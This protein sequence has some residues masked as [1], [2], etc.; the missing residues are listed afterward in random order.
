M[1]RHKISIL[2]LLLPLSAVQICFGEIKGDIGLLKMVADGYEAHLAK[3]KTWQ[4]QASIKS[5]VPR[6]TGGQEVI[7]QK[8]QY[9]ADFLIDRS[10]NTVRWRWFTIEKIGNK[11]GQE[12]K[13]VTR[14]LAGMSKGKCDYVLFYSGYG[15]RGE[16][17]SL[18]IY[19]RNRWPRHFEGIGFDPIH[20]LTKEIYPG[21]LE[22]LRYY[23]ELQSE[24]KLN[25]SNGGITRQGDIVTLETENDRGDYGRII[26]RFVFDLSKGCCLREFFTSSR[27]SE[28][29]CKL[30]YEKI[31]DVFVMK[32]VYHMHRD[33]RQASVRNATLSNTVVNNPIDET[34]FTLGRLGLKCGDTI[35]DTRT[36]LTYIFGEE[37]A[38]EA[39]MPP[40]ITVNEPLPDFDGIHIDFDLEK[41]KGRMVI[42]CFFDIDQRPS[43]HY[44]QQL[45]EQNEQIRDIGVTI[46]AIHALKIEQEKL[47]EWVKEN[48]IQFPVGI[49]QGEEEKT[50]FA[51]GFRSLPWLILTDKEHVVRA[52]GFSINELDE[53]IAT[54]REK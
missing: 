38:T 11:E 16:R 45:A 44:L 32:S 27:V 18:N 19:P 29:R 12:I 36:N 34:E 41:T 35:K 39:D 10:G 5:S 4:G 1:Y 28:N 54:L 20:I 24:G 31:A 42:V 30:D 9:R 22:Q 50:R 46:L 2:L 26:T 40:K 51:W 23:Y 52:E 48:N 6:G 21:L 53:K 3:L 8:G 15:Q 14:P 13:T 49:I 17:R 25:F 47:D 7:G 33:K 43:R 37:G